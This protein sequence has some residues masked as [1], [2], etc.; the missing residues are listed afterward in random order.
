MKK[1]H[2]FI[3][4]LALFLFISCEKT[5]PYLQLTSY[6]MSFG[7]FG[8]PQTLDIITNRTWKLSSNDDWIKI[9]KTEK[10]GTYRFRVT[11]EIP[12][13]KEFI[14]RIGE[15]TLVTPFETRKIEIRQFPLTPLLYF[16]N[17]IRQIPKTSGSFNVELTSNDCIWSI[18]GA[19]S[20]ISMNPSSGKGSG[21]I[22][23]SHLQNPDGVERKATLKFTSGAVSEYLEI[24]QAA[25][26]R[27][28]EL[29]I[30]EKNINSG[31]GNFILNISTNNAPWEASGLPDWITLSEN[32]AVSGKTIAVYYQ[33]ND[34]KS[35]R[36]CSLMF[37]SGNEIKILKINQE[38]APVYSHDG[39]T[40]DPVF[41]GSN[42]WAPVNLGY[43]PVNY[44]YGK[45][46]QWGR[47]D[48]Q[49]YGDSEPA[50]EIK[51]AQNPTISNPAPNVFYTTEISP[52]DWHFPK[53][54]QL[55]GPSKTKNDS[56]PEGWRI[57]T[58]EEGQSFKS[59]I[60][61]MIRVVVGKHGESECTGMYIYGYGKKGL[62]VPFAGFRSISGISF[63]RDISTSFWTSG[64][65]GPYAYALD[66]D[67]LYVSFDDNVRSEAKSIRCVKE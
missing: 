44:K 14:K 36:S 28:I 9:G 49:G 57:P 11:I 59:Y 23:V 3:A 47:K 39:F 17:K 38:K 60:N 2:I 63:G 32:N 45:L 7:P 42:W 6:S 27:V 62:F 40:G 54:D 55:W 26:E 56:C 48:G 19:P 30:N 24:I 25:S 12:Y 41:V 34:A 4:L 13:Y 50:T 15:I 65:K 20:W 8:G 35:E 18:S 66:F 37:K 67:R 43:D 51:I 21:T 61:Q 10:L 22:S 52:Y 31:A 46:Y 5:E 1:H 29:N 64:V 33:V 58:Y 53:D 16:D